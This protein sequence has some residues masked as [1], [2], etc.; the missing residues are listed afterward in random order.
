MAV[1]PVATKRSASYPALVQELGKVQ[2]RCEPSEHDMH[3]R[4]LTQLTAMRP[5]SVRSAKACHDAAL[6]SIAYAPSEEVVHRAEALIDAIASWS[7]TRSSIDDT[8]LHNSGLPGASISA[9]FSLALNAWLLDRFGANVE[10][11]GDDLNEQMLVSTL[12]HLLDPVEQEMLHAGK[13]DWHT[14]SHLITGQ[15]D[16][17]HR[18]KK[19]IVTTTERLP[20]PTSLREHL[21]AQFAATTRWRTTVDDPVHARARAAMASVMH[22]TEGLLRSASLDDALRSGAPRRITLSRQQQRQVCDLAKGTLCGMLR[23]TDPVTYANEVETEM[24]DMGRGLAIALYYAQADQK[25]AVQSYVG[26]MAFKNRVPVAYGGGWVL[27]TES[28]FGVNVF[29]A[30]RGGESTTIVVQLLRLYAH[31]F[32][33]RSFTVD[34]YQIG[35]DNPDG[36]ASA[37][38]WF[39]YRLGFRPSERDL[40]ALAAREWTALQR[41]RGHR[42]P[43]S[44]LKRLAYASMRWTDPSALDLMPI[45]ADRLGDVVSAF[46][47]RQFDGDRVAALAH[48][49]RVLSARARMRCTARHPVARIAVLLVASGWA[50][51]AKPASLRSFINDY[52]LKSHNEHGY[53]RAALR[54][55][56]LF[57]CLAE[58]E[59]ALDDAS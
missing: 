12:H 39:Y 36:I 7:F 13:S 6:F 40:A 2:R 15:G 55:A 51:R 31:H 29:P 47:T 42:T 53:A 18:L 10:L 49:L 25:M 32:G 21:F 54:H 28:G 11:Q 20:G 30:F 8:P 3:V 37:S 34:P 23:E 46:V 27:G 17:R 24:F 5:P 38:F 56:D 52:R 59:Q 33:V 35:L 48:A 41:M 43:V 58:A 16:D 1:S 50:E 26:Y 19:W 22:H 44:T 57:H 9:N 4:L 14:W 45:T